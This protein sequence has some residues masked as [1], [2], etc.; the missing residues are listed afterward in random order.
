MTHNQKVC[1]NTGSFSV[2]RDI[3]GRPISLF[4]AQCAEVHSSFS[5]YAHTRPSYKHD[6][7]FV[8]RGLTDDDRAMLTLYSNRQE[9]LKASTT[10]QLIGKRK[11]ATQQEIRAHNK[12]FVDAKLLECK[13]WLDSEVF[14]LVD[15]RK[16]QARS[17]VTGRWVLTIKR[18][19]EGNFLETQARG[20]LRG[21]QDRRWNEQQADSPAAS[22]SRFRLAI[23]AAANKGWN[24]AHGF[25][26][27]LSSRRSL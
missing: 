11:E 24:I 8:C 3:D 7:E 19:K 13:S 25:E 22:R 27:S 12:Q 17:W 20:A 15:T 9:S 10:Q 6:I 14:D 2:P 18:D 26:N 23:Q 21:F 16:L 4:A 5:F 1:S